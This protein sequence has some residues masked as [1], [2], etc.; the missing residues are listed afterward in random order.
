MKSGV[1]LTAEEHERL[2]F[3]DEGMPFV[4]CVATEEEKDALIPDELRRNT[5]VLGIGIIDTLRSLNLLLEGRVIGRRTKVINVG[6]A[7]TKELNVGD[8]VY[9]DQAYGYMGKN[10]GIPTGLIS[11][12]RVPFLKSAEC[13][14]CTEFLEESNVVG[15]IVFDME[16]IAYANI[17][18]LYSIKV[19]SDKLNMNQYI[20]ANKK[21][22]KSEIGESISY[23]VSNE[24]EV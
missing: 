20:D 11:L 2:S 10:L 8:I 7:G 6:F 23:I 4:I 14:T 17:S 1:L 21:D 3:G 18:K 19:V 24:E 13:A 16:L 12:R 5:F 15:N 22:Y 9:I